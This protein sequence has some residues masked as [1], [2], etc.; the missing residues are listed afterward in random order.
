M[1]RAGHNNPRRTG[2]W[3]KQSFGPG[4]SHGSGSGSSGSGSEGAA[5]APGTALTGREIAAQMSSVP[6]WA[7]HGLEIRRKFSF[8]DFAGSMAFVNKVAALAEAANHHPDIAIQWNKV[9]LTL[10][11]HSEKGL[12][13]KDFDLAKKIDALAS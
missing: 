1:H 9:S 3:K 10:T 4:S 13:S 11:T 8:A 6:A 5:S 12:T 7:Q 2:D